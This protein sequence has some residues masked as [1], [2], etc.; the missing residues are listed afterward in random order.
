MRKFKASDP[1]KDTGEFDK[2]LGEIF[3]QEVPIGFVKG[4]RVIYN[5]GD[6]KDLTNEEIQGVSPNV[7]VVNYQEISKLWKNT[8]DVEIYLDIE[9]LKRVV[10]TNV[11]RILNKD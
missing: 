6:H 3:P 8:K 5:N 11:S 1:Q 7:G 9:K 4:V 10:E 2:L